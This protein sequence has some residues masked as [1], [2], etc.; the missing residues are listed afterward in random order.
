MEIGRNI[1]TNT[2]T[3]A[4][5][6]WDYIGS[7]ISV[8]RDKVVCWFLNLN[9]T[10][11]NIIEIGKYVLGGFIVGFLLKKYFRMGL[12]LIALLVASGWFLLEFNI[13]TVNWDNAQNLAHVTPNDTLKTVLINL[14]QWCKQ[15]M[16]IVIST[17]IGFLFG[18]K[19]G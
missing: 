17:I 3:A 5:Q 8:V 13:I 11:A 9:L 12:V 19:I 10:P 15:H 2:K 16:L 14:A 7:V 4:T 18:H 6:V 1:V